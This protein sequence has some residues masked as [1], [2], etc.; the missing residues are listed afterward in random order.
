MGTAE[1]SPNRT[2]A[3][4]VPGLGNTWRDGGRAKDAN[5][6]VRT[7]F[8]HKPRWVP[9]C[10]T[11]NPSI[12]P[13]PAWT[14]SS[15]CHLDHQGPTSYRHKVFREPVQEEKLPPPDRDKGE[16]IYLGARQRQVEQ[17]Q[18][19]PP[20]GTR[21][22]SEQSPQGTAGPPGQ[23]RSPTLP[24][25]TDGGA[26]S[27]R[28]CLLPIIQPPEWVSSDRWEGGCD[29]PLTES[30]EE[31]SDFHLFS[32]VWPQASHLTSLIQLGTHRGRQTQ[33]L[34]RIGVS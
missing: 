1:L 7:H 14:I 16:A 24:R 28:C 32:A 3:H 22:S 25:M 13:F 34:R 20:L 26:T 17:G 6:A 5:P 10:S 8:T 29:L 12:T 33:K 2:V 4:L 21:Y 23:Y 31:T 18:L 11:S 30:L 19:Q 9:G 27:V 15:S